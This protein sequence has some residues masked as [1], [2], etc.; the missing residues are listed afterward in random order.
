MGLSPLTF[1][2]VSSYSSDFQS[3]LTRAVNIASLPL[4]QLQN[5]ESD[6]L[7]RKAQ[8]SSFGDSVTSLANTF[9]T[10]ASAVSTNGLQANSSDSTVVTATASGAASQSSYTINSITSLASTASETSTTG[11]ADSAAT[12]VSASGSLKLVVGGKSFNI[13]LSN[14]QNNLVGLRNA[15]NSLGTGAT[16][17][18]L[19]TGT[20]A[21]ANYLSLSADTNGATTLQLFEDPT[22]TNT[23]LL[24]SANQGTDTVF[25]LNGIT[26]DRTSNV[27]NDVIPG[28]N[29]TVK[30]KSTTPVTL[31]LTTSRSALSS[32]LSSFVG[33][34][35]SLASQVNGQVGKSAGLLS[36]DHIVIET[37]GLLRQIAGY[38]SGGTASSNNIQSLADLGVTFDTTGKATFDSTKLAN[39]ND[40]QLTSAFGFVGTASKGFAALGSKLSQL[41]DPITGLI[42]SQQ[43][44]YDRTDQGLK[45]Q[46]SNLQDRISLMQTTTQSRLQKMDALLGSL[47]SQ[48]QIISASVN[49]VNLALFGKNTSA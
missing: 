38:T 2:G 40:A 8:L 15:V 27:V 34:Y 4:K 46:I 31:S 21:N 20:G 11:Y 22:G 47:Q 24:T 37:A 41:S 12:A 23:N 39:L 36:G 1:T 33:N 13:N 44:S 18:I 29:F 16:A 25:Q 7:Q 3:I 48:Q 43:D 49:A 26:V 17:S 30:A 28:V 6:L 42:K 19:T 45:N 9:T 32:A 5:T 14:S 35:N 10:L